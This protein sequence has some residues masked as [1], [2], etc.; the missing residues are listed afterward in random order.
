[1][2]GIDLGGTHIKAVLTDSGGRI[3]YESSK[4]TLDVEG[5]DN[6]AY[7]KKAIK[8]LILEIEEITGSNDM[9]IG[10]SSPGIVNALNT[11]VVSNG[12]KLLG[13]E[14]FEWPDYLDREVAVLNDAHAALYAEGKLGNAQNFKNIIM[15]TL[16]TGVGGGIMIDGKL[17]QGTLGRAG[18][19]GHTSIS[20]DSF[21][22]IVDTPGSLESQFA[23][24]TLAR[25]SKGRYT[26]TRG[27]VADYT[28]HDPFASWVWLCSIQ[29]LARGIVSLI[30]ILS[31][32]VIILGGGIAKAGK[33]LMDPLE[34][35]MDIYE[36]RPKGHKTPIEF[37]ALSNY[38]GAIGAALFAQ[39]QNLL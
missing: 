27:L 14:N 33:H 18:H 35:F 29:A 36:W 23:E 16:G 9:T 24:S 21:L 30:N 1:M 3:H 12:N 19:I 22:G 13:I 25:R 10:I 2:I 5:Q 8:D 4:P 34:D 11:G 7:W 39:D 37:A 20:D 28:R 31:P 32:E 26:T 38:A 15:L 17:I 6:S